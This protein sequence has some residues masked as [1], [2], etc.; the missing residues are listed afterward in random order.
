MSLY[1]R[2][3]GAGAPLIML[4]G[5]YGMS[6]NLLP[7]AKNLA[8]TYKVF[9]PD[10]RNH[11]QSPHYA[12]MNYDLMANDIKELMKQENIQ[13][14][15]IIGYSLGGKIGMKLALSN[16]IFIK[17]LVVI[18]ISPKQYYQDYNEEIIDIIDS[19]NLNLFKNIYEIK[20]LLK[21]KNIKNNIINV[22]VKNLKKNK[23]GSLK[24]KMNIKAI[25]NNKDK[26]LE[27]INSNNEYEGPVLFI[28]AQQSEYITNEDYS[29]I[30]NLFPNAV[31]IK[32]PKVSHW[33]HTEAPD[34]LTQHIKDFLEKKI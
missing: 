10:L 25:I 18:D 21:T 19:L 8:N 7:I 16:S 5:L 33:L 1:Y 2:V 23:T 14:S 20:Q 27:S 24:W 32:I 11:G 31:T 6:D 15:I 17:A 4:H 29:Y 13:N 3:I 9:L 26:L 28:K 30:Y 12:E 34:I 22:L